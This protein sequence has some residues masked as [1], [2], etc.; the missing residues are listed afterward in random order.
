MTKVWYKKQAIQ[1]A[2]IGALIAG[3]FLII[4]DIINI[5]S[6]K[7]QKKRIIPFKEESVSVLILPFEPLEDCTSRNEDIGNAVY[8]SLKNN[9]ITDT[10]ITFEVRYESEGF[11]PNNYQEGKDIGEIYKADIVIWG[12]HWERSIQDT[13]QVLYILHYY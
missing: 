12:V 6:R 3:I 8:K 2:I 13:S 9:I 5:D 1:A 7:N 11:C 4:S 10:L